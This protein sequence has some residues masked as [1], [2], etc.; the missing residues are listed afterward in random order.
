MR[1]FNYFY[2]SYIE[3]HHGFFTFIPHANLFHPFFGLADI[4]FKYDYYPYLDIIKWF[5]DNPLKF[6]HTVKIFF[7]EI[8]YGL[9][10]IDKIKYSVNS[11]SKDNAKISY[12]VK[13]NS[14]YLDYVEIKD[15]IAEFEVEIEVFTKYTGIFEPII[16]SCDYIDVL[17][18]N[19]RISITE[20]QGSIKMIPYLS[21]H[22]SEAL[23]YYVTYANK[24][25]IHNRNTTLTYNIILPPESAKELEKYN[26]KTTEIMSVFNP[27]EGGKRLYLLQADAFSLK[28]AP[29]KY[30]EKRNV[31]PMINDMWFLS[32][33]KHC[34][35]KA[36]SYWYTTVYDMNW[37]SIDL[38]GADKCDPRC[39]YTADQTRG[40]VWY[41][42]FNNYDKSNEELNELAREKLPVIAHFL[43]NAYKK[44]YTKD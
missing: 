19:Q 14:N 23:L 34:E 11:S 40:Y 17:L 9:I 33:Q 21:S 41:V 30:S 28:Y 18:F 37:C 25:T 43:Y 35:L 42:I 2:S 3:N 22:H 10:Y 6:K 7:P 12:V 20:H 5:Y 15:H 29:E 38:P 8:K 31:I 39:Q 1:Q 4:G 36:Q 16:V 32:G 26:L 24:A 13:K 44:F 27:L